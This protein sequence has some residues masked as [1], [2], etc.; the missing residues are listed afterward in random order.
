MSSS[1]PACKLLCEEH[2]IKILIRRAGPNYLEGL[3]KAGASQPPG[4]P[5]C[6]CLFRVKHVCL[7]GF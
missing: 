1:L 7:L 4:V 2:K 3:R 6:L 5:G